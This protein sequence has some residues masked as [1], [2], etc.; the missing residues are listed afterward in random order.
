MPYFHNRS[1]TGRGSV[2]PT[3]FF[4]GAGL[5]VITSVFLFM[6]IFAPDVLV[7]VSKPFWQTGA[8]VTTFVSNTFSLKSRSDLLNEVGTLRQTNGELATQLSI[9]SEKNKTVS[10]DLAG[11]EQGVRAHVL[12]RPPVSAYDTLV[13]DRGSES[14]IRID[15][16]VY[17]NLGIPVGRISETGNKTARVTLFSAPDIKTQG[18]V[19]DN[20]FPIELVGIGGGAF[21]V[22]IPKEAPIEIGESVFIT[23]SGATP[24]GTVILVTRE[25]SSLVGSISIQPF[26]NLFSLTQVTVHD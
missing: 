25:P 22:E 16:Y 12:V 3:G 9:L 20:K 17:S 8:T 1:S 21:K 6:R 7:Y 26:V 2:S 11:E 14:D 13:L 4:V 18:W 15:M 19:G 5:L 24:V 10:V 23:G